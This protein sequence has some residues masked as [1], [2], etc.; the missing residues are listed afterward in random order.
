MQPPPQAASGKRP[1]NKT[2]PARPAGDSADQR[3]APQHARRS[4]R[5]QGKHCRVPDIDPFRTSIGAEYGFMDNWNAGCD[6]LCRHR[7]AGPRARHKRSC[8]RL[9]RHRLSGRGGVG[10]DRRLRE[11]GL[12]CRWLRGVQRDQYHQTGD[13]F[14]HDRQYGRNSRQHDRNDCRWGVHAK[15]G[16]ELFRPVRSVA[17]RPECNGGRSEELGRQ[18][19]EYRT[20]SEPVVR[21][22]RCAGCRRRPYRQRTTDRQLR[23]GPWLAGKSDRF[24][25]EIRNSTAAENA[26]HAADA[27]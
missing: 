16:D 1:R 9:G 15:E 20:G 22:R 25:H 18:R 5:D 24:G 26:I 4:F 10:F 7:H 12:W 14:G 27:L 6:R 3:R 23:L 11:R 17:R 8:C 19:L 13:Q 21:H 2:A